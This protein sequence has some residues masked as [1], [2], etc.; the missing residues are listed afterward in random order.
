MTPKTPTAASELCTNP[1][2]QHPD[3]VLCRARSLYSP[4]AITSSQFVVVVI[5][6][7]LVIL[8]IVSQPPRGR[9]WSRSRSRLLSPSTFTHHRPRME[10]A[11][12]RRT[13]WQPAP[14]NVFTLF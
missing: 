5:V 11:S 14:P 3:R 12:G 6:P 4:R 7:R 13:P 2:S 8:S 9:S 1:L 10:L